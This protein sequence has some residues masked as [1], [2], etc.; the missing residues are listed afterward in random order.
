MKT[1]GVELFVYICLVFKFCHCKRCAISLR[2]VAKETTNIKLFQKLFIQI[3][4]EVGKC[5]PKKD[6][7]LVRANCPYIVIG[8]WRWSSGLRVWLENERF[9]FDA[10]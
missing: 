5:S 6:Y 1:F 8:T 4:M 10:Y 7:C 2:H 3:I 9:E